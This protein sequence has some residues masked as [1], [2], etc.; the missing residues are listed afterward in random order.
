MGRTTIADVAAAHLRARNARAGS[1]ED[2]GAWSLGALNADDLYEIYGEWAKATGR[3]EAT[4][5]RSWH[6]RAK[7]PCRA[8]MRALAHTNRGKELFEAYGF[9]SLPGSPLCA[10]LRPGFRQPPRP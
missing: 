5:G 9:M 2:E 6:E 8:V 3:P 4:S 10:R 7:A 1:V